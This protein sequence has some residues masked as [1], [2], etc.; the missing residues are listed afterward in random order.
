MVSK[1]ELGNDEHHLSLGLGQ[2]VQRVQDPSLTPVITN[3]DFLRSRISISGQVG[4][5]WLRH[6]VGVTWQRHFLVLR[7]VHV[8]GR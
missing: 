7:P 4:H 8:D 5:G 6:V 1:T 2:L 3:V